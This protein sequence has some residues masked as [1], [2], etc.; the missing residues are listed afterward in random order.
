MPLT[1]IPASGGGTGKSFPGTNPPFY[2][3]SSNI[4]SNS[5]VTSGTNAISAGPI[6]IASN[7]SVT[8]AS[9]SKWVVL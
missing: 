7:V 4:T 8:I 5:T 3:N 6:T 9:G 1:I 2:V